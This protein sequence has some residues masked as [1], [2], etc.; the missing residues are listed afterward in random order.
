[1]KKT[2]K[3]LKKIAESLATLDCLLSLATVA[4]ERKYARP[5]MQEAGEALQIVE[6]RH[7]VVEAIS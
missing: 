4:K 5:Q 7:P 6:G 1:M 3:A 2:E